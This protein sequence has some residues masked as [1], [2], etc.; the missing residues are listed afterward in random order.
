MIQIGNISKE[1]SQI[2]KE[3]TNKKEDDELKEV[4]E[5]LG[6]QLQY[7]GEKLGK[8]PKSKKPT[9]PPEAGG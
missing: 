8:K 7:I 9:Q 6:T 1:L 2:S 4:I 3:I 5:N